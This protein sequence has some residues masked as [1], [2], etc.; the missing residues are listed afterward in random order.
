MG[1]NKRK[2][3][4]INLIASVVI[5]TVFLIVNV[6][7]YKSYK[8]HLA[9][10]PDGYQYCY[11]IDSSEKEGNEL[12]IKGWFLEMK[13]VRRFETEVSDGDAELMFALLPLSGEDMISEPE[14]A[15]F[16]KV[17]EM[18]TDR[19]EINEYFSCEYDYSKCGFVVTVDCDDL[20]IETTAYRLVIK[21]DAMKSLAVLTNVYLTDEGLMLTDPTQSPDLDT[22]G[23]DL[24]RIV[25]EGV[26][27]V[28][29]PDFGCYVYQ[30]GKQLYWIADENYVFC[31]DGATCI[32]Y[33]MDTTQVDNLPVERLENNCFWSNIGDMFEKYEITNQIDCGKYRVSTRE[34]P[35]EYSITNIET[36]YYSGDWVWKSEFK[37]IYAMLM[38]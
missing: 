17:K 2:K 25:K 19:P 31:E 12:L 8:Q 21:P 7:I 14:N 34:I 15:V 18:K 11:G 1:K 38:R 27:L 37:P 30:L 26:R 6:N 16:M 28:S 9:F 36:G 20:N 10:V 23:T 13:S 24:D 22:V 3:I 35:S 29:R 4:I 5:M 33:Q 32:E